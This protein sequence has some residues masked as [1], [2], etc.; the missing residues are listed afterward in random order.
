MYIPEHFRMPP[1]DL[2]AFLDVPRA[3]TLVTVGP[4]G[5]PAATYVPWTMLD[6]RLTTHIGRVNP[7][8]THT[9]P[10][11]VVFMGDDAYVSEEWMAPG[12]APSWAYETVQVVGDVIMHD[13]PGWVTQSWA[14]MLERFSDSRIG[15]YD[16]GWLAAQARATTG[17]EVI[18]TDIQGKSKLAQNHSA[19]EVTTIAAHLDQ[20]CPH[21]AER[22]R[23]VSLPHIAAREE[24]VRAAVPYRT[25]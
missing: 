1:A 9:G 5:R 17:V 16:P 7:Q 4:D 25:A 20:R 19:D 10:G 6:D 3:G 18:V 21:L 22:M 13:D 23:T 14:D 24:R 11:L 12:A 15:D 2:R 8:A